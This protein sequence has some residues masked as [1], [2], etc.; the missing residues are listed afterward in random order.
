[1]VQAN[2]VTTPRDIIGNELFRLEY[3][4]PKDLLQIFGIRNL[5]E[6]FFQDNGF[7]LF[8]TTLAIFFLQGPYAGFPVF[9][10]PR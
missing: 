9:I 5:L 4:D 8:L 7:C 2:P 10:S 1:M 6:F 3:R